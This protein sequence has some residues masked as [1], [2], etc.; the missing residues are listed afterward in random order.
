M[1]YYCNVYI[2]RMVCDRISRFRKAI[3]KTLYKS[4][5]R[6]TTENAIKPVGTPRR[7]K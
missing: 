5:Q 3:A 4:Q 6:V 7:L 2:I 1:C